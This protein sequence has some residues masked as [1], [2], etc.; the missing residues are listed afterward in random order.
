MNEASP[1]ALVTMFFWPT[2]FLP[3]SPTEFEKNWTVKVL[4]GLLLSLPSIF[5]S[6]PEVS[7]VVRFGL[8]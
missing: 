6:L 1:F 7:A 4:L 8:F 2:S 3:S 5:V